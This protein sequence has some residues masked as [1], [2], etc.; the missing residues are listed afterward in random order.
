MAAKKKIIP[1]ISTAIIMVFVGVFVFSP[2]DAFPVEERY[3]AD[4]FRSGLV[5]GTMLDIPTIA[6]GRHNAMAGTYMNAMN[7]N[8]LFRINSEALMPVP[9]LV[10]SVAAISNTVFEFTLHEG[11][12][13]HNGEILAAYNIDCL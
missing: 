4:G 3:D 13:F 7:Y 10:Y 11:I 12:Q 5:V 2:T 1:A 6:P 9:D 8:G